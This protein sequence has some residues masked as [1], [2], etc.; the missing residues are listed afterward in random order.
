M[1]NSNPNYGPPLDQLLTFAAGKS[2]LPENWPNYLELGF[3]LEHVPDLIRMAGD[4]ELNWADSESLEVWAP[5]HAWR[6][7]GQ[8]RAEE[9][10]EPL[11]ALRKTL[12][13]SDWAIDELPEVL[14][15]I[16][17]AAL[18]PLTSPSW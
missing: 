3:G 7:L 15:M 11:I 13:D 18:P 12:E 5:L 10:I 16:G 6:I 17:P 2:T 8:L 9:A 4:E 14:G 1:E